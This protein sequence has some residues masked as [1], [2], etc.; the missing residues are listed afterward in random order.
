MQTA[1][2]ER[3]GPSGEAAECGEASAHTPIDDVA[4]P[5]PSAAVVLT[6][7]RRYD[8]Q[9]GPDADRLV[10]RSR[11]GDIVLRIEVTDTGPVLSFSGA[12]LDL[13]AV[14]RLSITAQEVSIHASG[15]VSLNAGGSLRETIAGDH[16]TR[17]AGA[18]R[19]EAATVQVQ[20]N[21]GGVGVRANGRIAL[22]GE[23]IGLNDEPEPKPFGW[24]AIADGPDPV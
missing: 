16:H 1:D 21:E 4:V 6:S 2:A 12:S 23:H 11:A 15:D 19:V 9:A 3:P 10:V 5:M 7:G 18:E 13:E 24:S 14:R 20:A 8:I 17:V 22:D